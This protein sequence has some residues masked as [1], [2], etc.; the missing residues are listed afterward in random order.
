MS[1]YWY[2]HIMRMFKTNLYTYCTILNLLLGYNKLQIYSKVFTITTE[3]ILY[4]IQRNVNEIR[5]LVKWVVLNRHY[6]FD[7]LYTTLLKIVQVS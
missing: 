2:T 4:N 5:T 3:Y 7:I 1:K 6:Q